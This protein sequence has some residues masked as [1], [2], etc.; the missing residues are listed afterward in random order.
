ME[1]SREEL[2]AAVKVYIVMR[3]LEE[4]GKKFVKKHF[5]EDLS[6][7]FDRTPKA[8]EYRME[9][10]SYVYHQLGRSWLKGLKPAK[11]VGSKV[12]KVIQELISENES[13]SLD[14]RI[15]FEDQVTQLRKNKVIERP[16]GK[17]SPSKQTTRATTYDR[18]PTVGAW[19]LNESKGVCESCEKNAP[20]LKMDGDFYL[21]IHHL[22]RLADG[23]SDTISNAIAICPNCHREL[24][25]GAEREVILS[26]LYRKIDRLEQE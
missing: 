8:F 23:G 12:F 19:L 16:P 2:D 13:I 11:N 18:D 21:E 24:H 17:Q 20:F 4:S 3:E 9:N 15:E 14:P 26:Q 1:W 5:Y 10:I 25:Y 7:R 6:K 22:R